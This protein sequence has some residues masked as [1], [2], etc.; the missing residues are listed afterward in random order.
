MLQSV[1]S[2]KLHYVSNQ[3]HVYSDLGF[4]TLCAVIEAVF[5]KRIDEV[6]NEILPPQARQKLMWSPKGK[7]HTSAYEHV[8]SKI[9][10]TEMCPV[11]MRTIVGDVHDLNAYM[12]V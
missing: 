11:R 8:K 9:A 7:E 2:E 4:M 1:A 6:W 5:G 10:A 12:L 3:K